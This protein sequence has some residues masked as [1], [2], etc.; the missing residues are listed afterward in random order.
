MLEGICHGGP[1]DGQTVAI[2]CPD[3]FLLADKPTGRAWIYDHRDGAFHLREPE[4]RQLDADRAL[5]A[6][7][8]EAFDV[9]ALPEGVADG[10]E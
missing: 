10:G 7:M 9:V 4:P 5:A 3:G 1:L 6:A 2:G 8:S